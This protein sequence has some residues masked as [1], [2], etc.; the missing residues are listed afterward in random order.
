MYSEDITKYSE[1]VKNLGGFLI[2]H[3]G[4]DGTVENTLLSSLRNKIKL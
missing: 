2:I 1:L 4:G 3:T